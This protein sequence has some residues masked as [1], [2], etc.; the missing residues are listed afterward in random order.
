[1]RK[2]RSFVKKHEKEYSY[3]EINRLDEEEKICTCK[4][5]KKELKVFKLVTDPF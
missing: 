1:M 2:L 5:G 3:L 4:E